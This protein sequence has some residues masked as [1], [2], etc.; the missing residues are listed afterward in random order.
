MI[1]ETNWLPGALMIA[2]GLAAGVIALI[3][4]KG[5]SALGAGRDA[6]LA[7]L[8][9][10]VSF[11]L[12]QLHALDTER[13]QLGEERFA[14]DKA[15]LE[16]EAAEALRERDAFAKEVAAASAQAQAG[17]ASSSAAAATQPKGFFGRHPQLAGALWGGGVVVFFAVLWFVLTNEQF[18]RGDGEITGMRP[19]SQGQAAPMAQPQPK[20]DPVFKSALERA[21]KN[22]GDTDASSFA[23]HELIRLQEFDKANKLTRQALASDPFHLETRIHR[24]VL[25]ATEGQFD[26]SI[27]ELG[28]LAKLYPDSHEALLFRGALAMQTGKTEIA[29]ESF[30]RFAAL[31]P[32]EEQPPQIQSAITLLRQ[33]LGR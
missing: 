11:L 27:E 24:A 31:A 21:E 23:V 25:R 13:H 18:D 6:K 28:N 26:T 8:E 30:E 2:I 9:H 17:G 15:K 4:T 20:E 29:L 5:R 14:Q 1:H 12:D 10:R 3:F 32:K 16:L 19:P 7:D 33:R 22:P